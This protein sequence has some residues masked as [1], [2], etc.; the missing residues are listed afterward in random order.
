MFTP[1]S[2]E[3]INKRLAD[4]YGK[5]ED[6]RP[7]WRVVWSDDQ[8]E[9][10]KMTHT[11]EGFELLTPIVREVKKYSYIHHKYVLERLIPIP[12]FHGQDLVDSTSYEPVWTFEDAN[13][14][15]LP[16]IWEAIYLLIRTVKENLEGAGKRAPY[17]LPEEMGNTPEAIQARVEKL[18]EQL[19]GNESKIGDALHLDTAVG[20]G[21]RDR[22]DWVN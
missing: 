7:N 9:K 11:D 20:Y 16:P 2:L 18:Q 14:N 4:H 21:K 17:K 13:G 12:A 15:P 5:F 10:R 19:F 6:G 22:N 3:T 1:E 8:L